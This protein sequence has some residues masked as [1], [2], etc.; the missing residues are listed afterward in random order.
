MLR[1]T[2]PNNAHE[3]VELRIEAPPLLPLLSSMS[4]MIE[5]FGESNNLPKDKIFVLI[6]EVDELL[7]NYV[8]H[9]VHK[10]KRPKVEITMRVQREKVVLQLID[11]GPPFNPDDAPKP[12]LESEI[13]ERQ[14]GGLGLHLVR[15]YCDRMQHRVFKNCNCVT[16]E[17]DLPSG[18]KA[19]EATE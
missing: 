4:E 13:M 15:T 9:G 12:D 6:L 2:F 14:A 5:A 7:T 3:G 16:L 17:H 19:Q 10:V 1:R 8:R 11:T 18:D